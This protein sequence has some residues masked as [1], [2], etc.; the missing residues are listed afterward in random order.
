MQK[1]KGINQKKPG[2]NRAR[3]SITIDRRSKVEKKFPGY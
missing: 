2:K 3:G 1:M